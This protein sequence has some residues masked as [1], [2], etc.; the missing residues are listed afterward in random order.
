MKLSNDSY[1]AI[2]DIV[3]D[4]L[5]QGGDPERFVDAL[6]E[7]GIEGTWDFLLKS[8]D[9][10]NKIAAEIKIR[11]ASKKVCWRFAIIL[12]RW[13]LKLKYGKTLAKDQLEAIIQQVY[14]DKIKGQ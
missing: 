2:R 14:V 8:Q 3:N 5:G 12:F 4:I 13:S 9:N 1:L 7:L 10:F 11:K 6:E